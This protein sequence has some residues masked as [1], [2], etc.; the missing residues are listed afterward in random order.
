VQTFRGEIGG[1]LVIRPTDER[2]LCHVLLGPSVRGAPSFSLLFSFLLV[3]FVIAIAV[4]GWVLF[5]WTL[6]PLPVIRFGSSC[7]QRWVG[8]CWCLD[9]WLDG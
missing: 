6:D 8:G 4:T 5:T 9:G 2:R 3:L 7:V 1:T